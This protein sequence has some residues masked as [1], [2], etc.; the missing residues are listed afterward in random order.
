MGAGASEAGVCEPVSRDSSLS[1]NWLAPQHASTPDTQSDR[2]GK[3]ADVKLLPRVQHQNTSASLCLRHQVYINLHPALDLSAF[4]T[5]QTLSFPPIPFITPYTDTPQ[6][7]RPSRTASPRTTPSVSSRT[8]SAPSRESPKSPAPRAASRSLARIPRVSP[9]PHF[10]FVREVERRLTW[11]F[12]AAYRVRRPRRSRFRRQQA[13]P[14]PRHV[15]SPQSIPIDHS[16]ILPH[17]SN[18]ATSHDS[19]THPCIQCR[20]SSQPSCEL[21]ATKK[22]E[23]AQQ[24]LQSNH[25]TMHRPSHHLRS[26]I[27]HATAAASSVK[28]P[29]TKPSASTSRSR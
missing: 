20:T 8:P 23:L 3:R 13:C 24:F 17:T 22:R 2:E 6:W 10:P 29:T 5:H 9:Q 4:L 25:N 12:G 28:K 14:R 19:G 11:F 26:R 1:F 21:S 27:L 18:Q 7:R 15:I 16:S